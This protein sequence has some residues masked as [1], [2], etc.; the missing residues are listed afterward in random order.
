MSNKELYRF[1]MK[2]SRCSRQKRCCKRECVNCPLFTNE[3]MSFR[4]YTE[5]ENILKARDPELHFIDVME[6]L[7][8]ILSTKLSSTPE[9]Q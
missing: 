4:Y 8:K 2:E 7:R 9:E 1:L 6:E 5:L 3:E